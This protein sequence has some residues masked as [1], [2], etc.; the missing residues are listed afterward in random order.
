M[1]IP[2]ILTQPL[3]AMVAACGLSNTAAA[4]V[5]DPNQ[6]IDLECKPYVSPAAPLPQGKPYPSAYSI[7]LRGGMWQIT[8]TAL[9]TQGTW[10]EAPQ[11]A[12]MQMLILSRIAFKWKNGTKAVDFNYIGTMQNPLGT[13]VV[14]EIGHYD[15]PPLSFF[16]AIRS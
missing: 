16:C 13:Y 10:A 9:S 15:E 14:A 2:K 7:Q 6:N 5:P 1:D 8:S 11:P 4:Q 12:G 3:I